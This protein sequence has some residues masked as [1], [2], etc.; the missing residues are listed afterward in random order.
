M[1]S[2][3]KTDSRS[4]DIQ[5]TRFNAP[6]KR[7]TGEP[8][9]S[10]HLLSERSGT[11]RISGTF[12]RSIQKTIMQSKTVIQITS[13]IYAVAVTGCAWWALSVPLHPFFVGLTWAACMVIGL[14]HYQDS[15][16]NSV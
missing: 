4:R 7:R 8:L 14:L 13:T 1:V 15:I 16:N 10:V 6:T 12:T 3:T 11:T 2:Y 5:Q 9:R